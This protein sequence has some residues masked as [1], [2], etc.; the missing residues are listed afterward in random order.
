MEESK[1]NRNLQEKKAN[2]KKDSFWIIM[3][4]IMQKEVNAA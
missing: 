2:I 4:H 1:K 3:V